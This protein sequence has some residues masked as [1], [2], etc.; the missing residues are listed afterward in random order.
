[1]INRY[2]QK[3]PTRDEQVRTI[4]TQ[5]AKLRLPVSPVRLI[6]VPAPVADSLMLGIFP[7]PQRFPTGKKALG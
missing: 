3:V 2:H 6:Q 4:A 1:M 7:E 5:R